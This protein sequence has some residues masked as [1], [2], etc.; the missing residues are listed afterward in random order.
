MIL[1]LKSRIEKRLLLPKAFYF[2]YFG[3]GASLIPFLS[4]YYAS[5]GLSPSKIGLLASLS[6][7]LM[8]FGAPFWGGL[9]DAT[10]Q[11]RRILLICISGALASVLLLSSTTTFAGLIPVVAGFSF[12]V[13]PVMSLIDNSVLALLEGRQHVYGR[14]RVWGTVGWGT[15]A[16]VI[17]FLADR[18]GLQWPFYG[19]LALMAVGLLV[20][21][22]LPI[23]PGQIGVPFWQGVRQ[24][25]A[26]RLWFTFLGT[27]LLSGIISTILNNFLFLYLEEIGFSRSLMGISITIATLSELPVLFFSG[28]LVSRLGARRMVLFAMLVYSIRLLALSLTQSHAAILALQLLHGATFAALWVA[29]VAYASEMAPPG[30]G[31]TAQG[32]LFSAMF[33]WGG[34]IGALAGGLLFDAIGPVLTFRWIALAALAGLVVFT[35]LQARS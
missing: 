3:A 13:S 21:L 8:L 11:H 24:L 31:A 35:G 28:R 16:L 4:L 6:P 14:Q 26:N 19:Y 23:H 12:M 15:A 20:V 10:R 32:M 22:R 7:L 9:A 34:I 30:L 18:Y 25:L 17:G 1:F 27:I 2:L 5:L 33:G 29:G